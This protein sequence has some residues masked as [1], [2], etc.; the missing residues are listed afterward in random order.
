MEGCRCYEVRI[1][2]RKGKYAD[3]ALEFEESITE[4]ALDRESRT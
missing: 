3:G 1:G 2:W 4:V